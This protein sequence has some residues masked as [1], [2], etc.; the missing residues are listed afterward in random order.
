ML[1]VSR[2]PT[3]RPGAR[4]PGGVA[5]PGAWG[6]AARSAVSLLEDAT[7]LGALSRL[8]LATKLGGWGLLLKCKSARLQGLC[9]FYGLHSTRGR[10]AWVGSRCVTSDGHAQ[11]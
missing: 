3:A 9:V 10:S 4:R 11:E 7:K 8:W 2:V 5:R 1:S 6:L